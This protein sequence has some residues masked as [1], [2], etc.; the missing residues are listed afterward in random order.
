MSGDMSSVLLFMA[1]FIVESWSSYFVPAHGPPDN[2]L[3]GGSLMRRDPSGGGEPVGPSETGPYD[4]YHHPPPVQITFPPSPFKVDC[5]P[6]SYNEGTW[7]QQMCVEQDKYAHLR[8]YMD[9]FACP[10]QTPP[11]KKL[12][13][14]VVFSTYMKKEDAEANEVPT[15]RIPTKDPVTDDCGGYHVVHHHSA[16]CEETC[17]DG[18]LEDY[19][20]NVHDWKKGN[21]SMSGYLTFYGTT[22][23]QVY[24]RLLD[25]TTS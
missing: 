25:D 4:A 15:D 12:G 6:Y 23:A 18:T 22:E 2:Q 20:A 19:I 24:T 21:C 14:N 1:L 16:L 7:C 9:K 13:N 17:T 5:H 8:D 3:A 11:F 10:D